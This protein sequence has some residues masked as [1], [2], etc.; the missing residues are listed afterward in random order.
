[1]SGNQ[2]AKKAKI[3][4]W[5][6]TNF[7]K[8]DGRHPIQKVSK[9]CFINYEVRQRKGGRVC[10]FNFELAKEMGLIPSGHTEELN[11]DLERAVLDSFG[12]VII[13]EYDK[14]NKTKKANLTSIRLLPR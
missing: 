6:Y 11:Q 10:A 12:I 4:S 9:D 8:I 1:M 2:S 3:K 13:N 7:E 14:I 5:D